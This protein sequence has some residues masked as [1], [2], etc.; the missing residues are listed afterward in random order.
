MLTMSRRAC[1]LLLPLLCAG[2]IG[3]QKT[4]TL[5]L[6]VSVSDDHKQL[7]IR[8]DGALSLTHVVAHIYTA[9]GQDY[10]FP[11]PEDTPALAPGKTAHVLLLSFKNKEGDPFNDWTQLHRIQVETEHEYWAGGGTSR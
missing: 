8:N 3:Q 2:C 9:N 4:R 6:D 10:S 1:L 11:F 7:L 5:K